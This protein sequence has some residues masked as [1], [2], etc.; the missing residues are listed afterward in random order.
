MSNVE[1]H[2]GEVD[3]D[4]LTLLK[5]H[6][7]VPI[8]LGRFIMV[9]NSWDDFISM[10]D[11]KYGSKKEVELKFG[12]LYTT[13]VTDNRAYTKTTTRTHSYVLDLYYNV[14]TDGTYQEFRK[15]V[16]RVL[17]VLQNNYRPLESAGVSTV[18]INVISEGTAS[19]DI[20]NIFG[21]FTLHRAS[22]TF[23]V[24]ERISYT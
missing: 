13:R 16:E 7:G 14:R 20:G 9:A 23:D 3:N 5:T 2:S 12:E 18:H 10:L 8:H 24:E 19:I 21:T 6:T 17:D 15:L 1:G 22:I 4:I 11:Q